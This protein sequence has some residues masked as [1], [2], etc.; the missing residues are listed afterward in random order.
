MLMIHNDDVSC[1]SDALTP[2]VLHVVC[3][4][5]ECTCMWAG[6]L[7]IRQEREPGVSAQGRLVFD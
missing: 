1:F 4:N 2:G 5:Y 6:L 3:G 7:V